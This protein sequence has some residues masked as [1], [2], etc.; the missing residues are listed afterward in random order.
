MQVHQFSVSYVQE[1]DRILVRINTTAGEELRVW[2]TR[3]LMLPL[4]PNLN[5]AVADQL[6]REKGAQGN[7]K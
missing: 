1:Q 5:K 6:Q 7:V 3:R 2:F 4:W